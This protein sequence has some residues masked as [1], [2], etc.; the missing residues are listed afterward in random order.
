M[1]ELKIL[2]AVCQLQSPGNGIFFF[3]YEVRNVT[4]V[5][6]LVLSPFSS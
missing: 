2:I 5:R 3:K 1:I 6:S 4:G